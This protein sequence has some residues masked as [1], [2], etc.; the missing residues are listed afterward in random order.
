ML[1]S[2]EDFRDVIGKRI[3]KLERMSALK[4][5]RKLGSVM[6]TLVLEKYR[7]LPV[8]AKIMSA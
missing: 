5:K 8:I 2:I 6:S 1:G 4:F 3:T 7:T